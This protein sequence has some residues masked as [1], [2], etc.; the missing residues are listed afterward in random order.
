MLKA[1]DQASKREFSRAEGSMRDKL[2]A[3]IRQ[4]IHN[5]PNEGDENI[6]TLNQDKSAETRRGYGKTVP[7]RGEKVSIFV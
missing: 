1:T 3:R 7:L 4:R 2:R 6:N 5:L